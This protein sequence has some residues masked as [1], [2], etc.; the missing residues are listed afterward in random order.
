MATFFDSDSDSDLPSSTSP[1]IT[2]IQPLNA[3]RSPVPAAPP[4]PVGGPGPSSAANRA[5]AS[6]SRRRRRSSTSNRSLSV[7][8]PSQRLPS[9][10]NF[11][12]DGD[13]L[14]PDAEDDQLYGGADALAAEEDDMRVL[15]GTRPEHR[16]LRRLTKAWIGER[17]APAL[18]RWEERLVDDVMH[19]VEQQVRLLPRP[20]CVVR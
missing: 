11:D 14:L 2:R 1:V 4:L 8:P 3:R 20:C 15:P 18:L 10:L 19:L 9:Q 7:S 12:A 13:V 6:T 16:A 17:A 5:S